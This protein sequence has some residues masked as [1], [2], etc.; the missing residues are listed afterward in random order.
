M[1]QRF[2]DVVV[3]S[4]S[5]SRRLSPRHHIVVADLRRR[6]L[7]TLLVDLLTAEEEAVDGR[8]RHCDSTSASSPTVWGCRGVGGEEDGP[9]RRS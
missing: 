9:V 3:A 4:G 2:G 1:P 6:R 8:T 5:G 7:G